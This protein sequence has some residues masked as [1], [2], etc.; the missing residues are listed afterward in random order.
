[1]GV[2][3]T[4]CFLLVVLW[5]AGA[6]AGTENVYLSYHWHL[7]QPIY[8]PEKHSGLNR[9]QYA[10]DSIDLKLSNS[11]NF[12]AGSN[13]RHPR[14]HLV[15][16]DGGEYDSVFDKADRV[17]AYQYGGKHSI[18]TLGA[19]PNAGASVSYSGALQ[20]NIRSLGLDYAYGYGP[21][22]NAGYAE[23]RG[24]QTSGGHPKAD[25]VGITYHHA[26]SP[27]L[28]ES[29]LRKEIEI[30]KEI[31]WKSW[32]G[33]P[34]RSDHSKGFWPVE[35]A[36][37]EAMIPVLVEQGYEWVIVPNNSSTDRAQTPRAR[38][39]TTMTA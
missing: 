7:H 1:M 22:W 17:I 4:R 15:N 32:G 38:P 14:N 5:A 3:K 27:L 23:A 34:D 33:T 26:F 12:Y 35:C 8:W 31:W 21:D 37:S 19:H 24:W 39:T 16:G 20:E 13:Y 10:K 29:V 28:P 36:F 30:F 18:A 9:Y 6:F 2:M 25:M 11:G